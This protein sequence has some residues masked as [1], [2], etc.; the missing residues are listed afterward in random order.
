MPH[1]VPSV[2]TLDASVFLVTV[3][4]QSVVDRLAPALLDDFAKAVSPLLLG[5]TF[6]AA[7]PQNG[8]TVEL[9]YT[10]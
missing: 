5:D 4:D 7:I 2:K 10:P 8:L 6:V 3:C 1:I 9:V